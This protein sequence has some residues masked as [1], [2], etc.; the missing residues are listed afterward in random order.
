MKPPLIL[1]WNQI[2]P[3]LENLDV[4][5]SMKNAFI[6]YSKGLA[7]IPPVGELIIDDAPGDV[8]IKYGFI[9]GGEHYVIKIASGFSGNTDLDIKP[10]QGMMLLFDLK[11]GQPITILIDD[12]NLTDIRTG[13]AGALVSKELASEGIDDALIIGTGVQARYQARYICQNMKIKN[14]HFWGRDNRKVNKLIDDLDH[15]KAN[16]IVEK[17]LE[18]AVNSSRLIITT[19]SSKK[20]FIKSDWIQK[21]THITAVGSDTHEKC[22]LDSKI[23]AKADLVVADSLEQNLLRGEIHQAIK[24]ECIAENKVIEIGEIFNR[25]Q[26]GRTAPS[27]ISVADLTG[28]AI[29]DLVIA[30][31]VYRAHF[32]N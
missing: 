25:S 19:T 4:N 29:Q 8:H 3:L 22:E 20:P 21:G 2:E 30:E 18:S 1:Q 12:A 27:Q 28:V 31:S 11:T 17:D 24:K 6:D 9:R 14:L 5:E 15:I 7:E 23:L 26:S 32:D 13:I 16:L 10:G